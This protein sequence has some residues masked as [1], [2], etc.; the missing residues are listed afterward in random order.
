MPGSIYKY[1]TTKYKIM[2]SI[3]Y[4]VEL[5]YFVQCSGCST[6]TKCVEK[7]SQEKNNVFYFSIQGQ[8]RKEVEKNFTYI[9][10]YYNEHEDHLQRS[11][12]NDFWSGD[13][14]KSTV[15]VL[16]PIVPLPLQLN[17]DGA[18]VFKSS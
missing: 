12:I 7:R 1:P 3:D 2:D 8:I 10:K 15:N 16:S 6:Y 13:I 17:T 18:N 9:E 11:D 5:T 14:F 4:P